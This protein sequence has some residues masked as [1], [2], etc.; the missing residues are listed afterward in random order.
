MRP[1]TGRKS[2]VAPATV[3]E[4]DFALHAF[5]KAGGQAVLLNSRLQAE[6]LVYLLDDAGPSILLINGEFMST[7]FAAMLEEP[8]AERAFIRLVITLDK[9]KIPCLA[10]E[11]LRE[12]GRE[13][14]TEE[15]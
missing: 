12:K 5:I 3:P 2:G 11:E 8:L 9:T 1:G 14:D 7:Y 6:E 15:L 10:W 4:H 13:A